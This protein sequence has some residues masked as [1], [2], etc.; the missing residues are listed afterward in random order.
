MI[1][2][3]SPQAIEKMRIAGRIIASV[4][5]RLEYMIE[6]GIQTKDLDNFAQ[7]QIKR[8]GGTPAFLGYRG[9]PATICASPDSVVV[10]G[11]PNVEPLLEGSIISIDLGVG[12]GGY[13]A[14][15]AATY[16]VGRISEIAKRLIEVTEESLYRGIRNAKVGFR[17]S[18]IS[19]TI[20]SYVESNGFNV[21]RIFVGHGIGSRLHE[22]PEIPNF[23]PPNKG[24]YL[25]S[26]MTLAIEPMVNEGSFEVKIKD[27]GWTAVTAD[28]G[29]SA[30]FEHTILITESEPEILTLWQRKNQL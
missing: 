29:L 8:S 12:Y 26:G 20:Q 1:E 22:E 23:G 10:H 14:D 6:P 18:D 2:I 21:V 7:E 16:P 17:L 24:P 28:G 4:F 19:Y 13:F 11:I 9:F 30:H 3:K 27:D 25:Q 15:A 5:Q